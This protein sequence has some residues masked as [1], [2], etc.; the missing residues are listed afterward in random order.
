MN[1][2]QIKISV[3]ITAYDRKQYILRAVDSAFNQKIRGEF[4]EVI[5]VKN[6][7]DINIDTQ[8][9]NLG[10]RV[11]NSNTKALGGKILEGIGKSNGDIICILED[12]DYFYG[13]KLET[14]LSE[15]ESEPG[16]IFFQHSVDVVAIDNKRLIS[17]TKR[18]KDKELEPPF[19]I[20]KVRNLVSSPS[21]S[22]IYNNSS[23]CFKKEVFE[24][25]FGPFD[26]MVR[27]CD[28]FLFLSVLSSN[29]KIKFSKKTLS[30]RTVNV[31][32]K[33]DRESFSEFMNNAAAAEEENLRTYDKYLDYFTSPATLELSSYYFMRSF[34]RSAVFGKNRITF[35][36]LKKSIALAFHLKDLYL[37]VLCFWGIISLISK[38]KVQHHFFSRESRR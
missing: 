5:V 13:D 27:A 24:K 6:F 18:S 20:K 2:N 17:R 9:S 28:D 35:S 33:S 29:G 38:E 11:Y 12:D 14:V 31:S 30:A 16:L 26:E 32:E 15:F 36:H 37:P 1:N 34:L 8:L 10:A 7:V 4:Y 23:Y 21:K 25:N 19:S 3:I 22:G